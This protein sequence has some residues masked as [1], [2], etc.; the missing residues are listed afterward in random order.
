MNNRDHQRAEQIFAAAIEITHLAG[1]RAY[2]D[3]TCAGDE[4]LRREVESLLAAHEQ[5]GTFLEQ[6]LTVVA[7]RALAVP[8]LG[9]AGVGVPPSATASARLRSVFAA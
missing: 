5:A 3:R 6:P 2:L 1:R 9:G 7:K 4:G 8:P